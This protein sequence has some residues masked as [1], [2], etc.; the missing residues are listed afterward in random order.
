[1]VGPVCI[2]LWSHRRDVHGMALAIGMGARFDTND[3]KS[4]A[5]DIVKKWKEVMVL[6]LPLVR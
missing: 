2:A 6:E 3:T 5:R 4:M 1:M